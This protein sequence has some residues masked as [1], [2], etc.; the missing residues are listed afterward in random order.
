MDIRK[1][2]AQYAQWHAQWERKVQPIFYRA[3]VNS[4]KP[5]IENLDIT[6]LNRDV[7]QDAYKKAYRLIGVQA[8][9][10]EYQN[11]KTTSG[12][13]IASFFNEVFAN[14]MASYG[15]LVAFNFSND[16]NQTTTE[17]IQKAL[18]FAAENYYTRSQTARLIYEYTLGKI[19]R[20]RAL[21][22]AR[23]E[24]TTASN[25]AK[26]KGAKE[27]LK[28]IG[29][30][31]GYKMWITRL[32]GRERHD[33]AIANNEAVLIDDKFEVGG[34]FC[35]TPGDANLSGKQRI[36]CRCTFVTLSEAGYW[37]RFGTN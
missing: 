24:T 7:W 17:Q 11:I 1:Y 37:R 25:Y 10:R 36:R 19:G 30:S 26:L 5:V 21:L 28:E 14:D 32:D 34:E 9:R 16:L 27:Y 8:G 13:D 4:I 33:H 3:L 18:V 31:T 6:Y 15:A 2:A 23:T 35:N 20:A 12:K 29:A 22:I